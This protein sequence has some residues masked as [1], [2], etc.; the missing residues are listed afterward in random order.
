HPAGSNLCGTPVPVVQGYPKSGSCPPNVSC[1]NPINRDANIPG[2]ADPVKFMQLRW[3]VI[4]DNA[5]T[6]SSN[7]D[8]NRVN[9]LMTELNNDF[10]GWKIQFCLDTVI[11]VNNGTYYNFDGGNEEDGMKSTYGANFTNVI[12]IYV[13]N[14]ITNPNAGGYAYFP[15]SA[16]GGYSY[17]G[18][19]L[20]ARGNSVVGTHTLGHELGHTFGLHHTFH[21]VDEVGVCTACYEEVGLAS[22]APSFGDVDGDF[23]SDTY[24]HPTNAYNCGNPTDPKNGCDAFQWNNTPV[25]NHMSYSFCS[26][27]FTSQQAGRMH[28]MINTYL[29]NW[30]NNGAVTCGSLPPVA[31]FSGNPTT[32]PAPATVNFT[33][34]TAGKTT[35][36]S[37]AW[38]F[39]VGGVGGV[40]PATSTLENPLQV[41]YSNTGAYTV[42][43]I[44][45]NANGTDTMIKTSYINVAGPVGDCDT[46][47]FQWITPAPSITI[48]SF[49]PDDRATGVPCPTLNAFA[50]DS[51][52]LYE[53]FNTPTPGSTKVGGV[54]LGMGFLNDPNDNMK[55]NVR[56]YG[57]NN[58]APDIA[59][60]PL[61]GVNGLSPTAAGF[62]GYQF[63]AEIWFP[64][65]S[66]ITI[67]GANFHAGVEIIPGEATDTLILM[68]S[69]DHTTPTVCGPQGE[70]DSSNYVNSTNFGLIDYQSLSSIDFD[71]DIV[72]ALGQFTPDPRIT[73]YAQT[74]NCDTT[75][76]FLFDSVYYS[77]ITSISFTFA[78]GVTY[79][80]TV[81]PG[82][83]ARIYYAAGPDTIT[84]SAANSCG[85]ADTNTYIIPYAFMTTPSPD[86]TKTQTNPVC[87]DS[88]VNFTATPTG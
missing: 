15:Y 44:A 85:K 51:L 77:S 69:C 78:D 70:N 34:L 60:G 17:R 54:R 36:T 46:L 87:K 32:W 76:V 31:D 61:G 33:N 9:N 6:P 13:V 53:R 48:Y 39:D 24:P 63:Y 25:D 23:C 67:P 86:F 68:S 84:I 7:I 4:R 35:V 49:G 81:D 29:G 19:V 16:Y 43:L 14:N 5:G 82:I 41:T 72:P 62:P 58:G 45:T 79:N 3:T 22:G 47:D 65:D 8:M 11:F 2:G 18:G 37:W 66:A 26:S 30:V 57:D 56:I 21:G 55:I 38:N 83:L 42:R 64:F 10:L 27:Q 50:T 80:D 59:S 40:T 20:M 28:C 74:V 12:N 73:S 71:L 1:D 75:T 88:T 52:G